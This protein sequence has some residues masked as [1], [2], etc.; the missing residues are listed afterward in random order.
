MWPGLGI[1]VKR[2]CTYVCTYCTHTHTPYVSYSMLEHVYLCACL[3]TPCISPICNRILAAFLFKP[4]CPSC[5]ASTIER[6]IV[7]SCSV[8]Y[9]VHMVH[10]VFALRTALEIS[11]GVV[12]VFFFLPSSVGITARLGLFVS[13]AYHR[14]GSLPVMLRA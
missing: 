4:L 11:R 2:S 9:I 13:L 7:Y 5:V 8:C 10:M 6:S 12:S 3:S 14:G 1:G